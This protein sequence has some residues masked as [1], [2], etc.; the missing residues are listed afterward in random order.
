LPQLGRKRKQQ[1]PTSR[2][3]GSSFAS[4]GIKG[5]LDRREFG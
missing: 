3:L 4:I 5:L 2:G 1:I